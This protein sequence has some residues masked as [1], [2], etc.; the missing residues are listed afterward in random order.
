MNADGNYQIIAIKLYVKYFQLLW[1][2]YFAKKKSICVHVIVMEVF[3]R[4]LC[5]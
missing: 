3:T 5:Q 4:H 2:I 1:A